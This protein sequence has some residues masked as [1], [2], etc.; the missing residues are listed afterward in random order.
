[1]LCDANFYFSGRTGKVQL[2]KI[3]FF[4]ASSGAI[5]WR[6]DSSCNIWRGEKTLAYVGNLL[7]LAKDKEGA[8]R[9]A[10][11]VEFIN[12]EDPFAK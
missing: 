11:M 10:F 5:V 8:Q 4:C 1:M 7:E 12:Q 6:Y 2:L 9:N 3:V